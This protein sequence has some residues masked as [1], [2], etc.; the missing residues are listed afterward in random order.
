MSILLIR[1]AETMA[2]ATRVVQTP[3]VPLNERGIAQ[4][5]RLAKRLAAQPLGLIL[6]SDYERAAHT[7]RCIQ[8]AT[9]AP[10]EYEPLLRERHYGDIRGRP[11]AEVGADIFATDYVPPNGESWEQFAERVADAWRAVCERASEQTLPVAVVTHGL[12]CVQLCRAHFALEPA[13]VPQARGFA[14]TG[15]TRIDPTPPHA[16][17]LLNCS[18]HL[19]GDAAPGGISGI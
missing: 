2:N 8:R 13:M 7:A 5:E 17:H 4:S 15:V 18:A 6:T 12:V 1:H 16:V 10:L 9:G 19:Q 3:D 11:Y 14:N